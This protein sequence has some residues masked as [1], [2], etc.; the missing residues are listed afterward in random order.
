MEIMHDLWPTVRVYW[1]GKVHCYSYKLLHNLYVGPYHSSL[2]GAVPHNAWNFLLSGYYFIS[3]HRPQGCWTFV[4]W[5][6]VY[7]EKFKIQ[8]LHKTKYMFLALKLEKQVY[9]L[10]KKI[11]LSLCINN[12]QQTRIPKAYCDFC[13]LERREKILFLLMLKF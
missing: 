6:N 2:H 9:C 10:E 13:D 5:T 7:Q 12:D 4:V 11:T 1:L 3:Y 8:L